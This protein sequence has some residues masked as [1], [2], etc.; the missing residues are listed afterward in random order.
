MGELGLGQV[1]LSRAVKKATVRVKER[2]ESVQALGGQEGP[3]YLTDSMI[4]LYFS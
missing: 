1:Q 4:F 2:G 3:F